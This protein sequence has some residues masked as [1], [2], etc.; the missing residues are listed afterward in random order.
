MKKIGENTKI[1]L[2]L[3]ELLKYPA[4]KEFHFDKS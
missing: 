2:F 3:E 4:C 1:D